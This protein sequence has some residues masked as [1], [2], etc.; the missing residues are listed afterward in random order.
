VIRT[1]DALFAILLLISHGPLWGQVVEG[2]PNSGTVR[3]DVFVRGDRDS[4]KMV[5]EYLDGLRSRVAGLEIQI[6]DVLQ[7]QTQLAVLNE[8]T[9][10]AGRD[11]PVLPAFH[12]CDRSYFGFVDKD[13]S[14]PE[15]EK[16]FTA[17]V[18]TRAT[19]PRC[20]SFKAF[21]PTLQK[22][23]PAIRFQIYDV[24]RD[25]NARA[26]WEALCHGSGVPPGLPT[27]DFARRVM[28]GYQSDEVTGAQLEALIKQVARTEPKK[29]IP[30]GQSQLRSHS[31]SKVIYVS[32]T[33]APQTVEQPSRSP[34]KRWLCLRK[35]IRPRLGKLHP[36]RKCFTAI[37]NPMQSPSP[38]LG[39]YESA[40]SGCRCSRWRSA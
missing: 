30:P 14:G 37:M 19:C 3:L 32:M 35:R 10:K 28:I 40:I 26:R 18:Y 34:P 17:D 31:T 13:K 4:S 22:R 33:T 12:C 25:A 5:A 6:H 9:K 2:K 27:I 23:W 8:I 38:F 16:L 11:K 29:P 15:I 1:L 39:D 20:L 7:D 36:I 24:D 21:L